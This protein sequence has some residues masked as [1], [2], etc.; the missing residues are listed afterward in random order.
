MNV[1]FAV[2]SGYHVLVV[3]V[4]ARRGHQIPWK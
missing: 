4:G 2:M 3:P 1:L